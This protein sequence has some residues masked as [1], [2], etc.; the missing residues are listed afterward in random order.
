M[1]R[2]VILSSEPTAGGTGPAK[3]AGQEDP[4]ELDSSLTL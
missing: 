1:P 4:V 3:S 2:Q